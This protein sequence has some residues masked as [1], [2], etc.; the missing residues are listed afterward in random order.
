MFSS[1]GDLL[2]SLKDSF[3]KRVQFGNLSRQRFEAVPKNGGSII[4]STAAI[5]RVGQVGPFEGSC[6]SY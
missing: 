4:R 3:A 1:R 6:R 2:L 5:A